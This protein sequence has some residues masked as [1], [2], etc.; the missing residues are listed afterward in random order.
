[1]TK[2]LDII[3]LSPQHENKHIDKS[4]KKKRKKVM[5][6][7][8]E[9]KNFT[10]NCLLFLTEKVDKTKMPLKTTQIEVYFIIL[11]K[12]CKIIQILSVN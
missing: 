10:Y 6:I 9:D 5:N 7:I 1:M 2:H 3:F 8:S 11:K 12:Y 4:I